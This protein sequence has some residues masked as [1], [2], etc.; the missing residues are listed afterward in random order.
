MTNLT[1]LSKQFFVTKDIHCAVQSFLLYS[2]LVVSD[3]FA[4]P[5]TI[6]CQSPLS[7]GFP[8]QEYWSGLPW[9]PPG[10]L[11]DPRIQTVSSAW[12]VDSLPLSHLGRPCTTITT[13]HFQNFFIFHLE[14]I[15][16]KQLTFHSLLPAWVTS[17]VFGISY[18]VLPI[19]GTS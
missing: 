6:V 11:P 10:C 14:T 8:R 3:S 15:S 4:T 7:M 2:H 16:I 18:K 12:Q 19:F 1:I 9:P 17:C 5:W 13:I